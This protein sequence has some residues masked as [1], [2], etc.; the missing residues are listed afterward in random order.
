MPWGQDITRSEDARK[1]RALAAAAIVLLALSALWFGLSTTSVGEAPTAI[2]NEDSLSSVTR[3]PIVRVPRTARVPP[4]TTRAL[5]ATYDVELELPQRKHI[6]EDFPA[7][8]WPSA[9]NLTEEVLTKETLFV[10]RPI[11]Y[12]RPQHVDLDHPCAAKSGDVP[13]APPVRVYVPWSNFASNTKYPLTDCPVPCVLTSDATQI[14]HVDAYLVDTNGALINEKYHWPTNRYNKT[15]VLFNTENV[16]GRRSVLSRSYGLRYLA[17]PY[18]HS[19]WSQFHIVVSYHWHSTVRLSFLEWAGC[20]VPDARDT[21]SYLR[22][23]GFMQKNSTVVKK[24]SSLAPVLF[25]ARNCDFVMHKRQGFVRQ[26]REAIEVDAVG[27]CLNSRE[28]TSIR[29]C[30]SFDHKNKR[31]CIISQYHFYLAIENS[32]SLDYVTEKVYEPLLVGTVP[33]YLGAPN[34][35]NFLP[36]AHSAVIATDFSSVRELALY[37]RC[38]QQNRSL[39]EYYVNWRERP[40]LAPFDEL[41]RQYAPLCQVCTIVNASRGA[42]TQRAFATERPRVARGTSRA[43]R[44]SQKPLLHLCKMAR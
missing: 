43:V 9:I 42:G 5:P 26:L 28:Q 18:N 22:K 2:G 16:E 29:H 44:G 17:K 23:K 31:L 33:V 38:L 7:Y 3:S 6:F 30:Q 27:K 13:T 36:A 39:Y 1:R 21:V 35:A 14:P 15:L 24:D 40:R 11:G 34:V 32:I 19:L 8:T 37:L 41:Q 20:R 4:P 12:Y 25:F 10:E